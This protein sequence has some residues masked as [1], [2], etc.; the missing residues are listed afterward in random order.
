MKTHFGPLVELSCKRRSLPVSFSTTETWSPLH[1]RT[2]VASKVREC[3]LLVAP[4]VLPEVE[5]GTGALAYRQ[6]RCSLACFS[7]ARR[8]SMPPLLASIPA[9]QSTMRASP[10]E[11][12]NSATFPA[13]CSTEWSQKLGGLQEASVNHKPVP[14]NMLAEG[15]AVAFAVDWNGVAVEVG[16]ERICTR[17]G[18]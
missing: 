1:T 16:S 13:G 6:R 9:C 5:E 7:A 2:T 18:R 14:M 11:T 17:T 3:P 12:K 4:S 15:G 8:R 10:A